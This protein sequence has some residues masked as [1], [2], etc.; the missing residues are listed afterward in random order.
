MQIFM[1][2]YG[3]LISFLF[4]IFFFLVAPPKSKTFCFFFYFFLKKKSLTL[5]NA[6][7]LP[8]K[9]EEKNPAMECDAFAVVNFSPAT[10]GSDADAAARQQQPQAEAAPISRPSSSCPASPSL[11]S[12]SPKVRRSHHVRQSSLDNMGT[13]D[14]LHFDRLKDFFFVFLFFCFLFFF[15]GAFV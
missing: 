7:P 10:A 13:S 11:Q 15:P 12:W 2:L 8:P 9:T 1:W 4:L 14:F 5:P 6:S 3:V